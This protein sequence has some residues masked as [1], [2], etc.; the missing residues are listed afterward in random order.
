MAD[1]SVFNVF[2]LE[3]LKSVKFFACCFFNCLRQRFCRSILLKTA[4]TAASARPAACVRY[5][6]PEFAGGGMRTFIQFIINI[7]CAADAG[8]ERKTDKIKKYRKIR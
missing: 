5:N 2:F 6:V 3:D 1:F 7:Y 8:S 4:L